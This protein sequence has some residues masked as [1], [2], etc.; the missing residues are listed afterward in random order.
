[1]ILKSFFKIILSFSIFVS[2]LT[3]A[4]IQE[5]TFSISGNNGETGTGSFTWDDATVPNGSTLA[6]FDYPS[7]LLSV[8]ITIS[9]GNIVGGSTSFSRADCSE[10]VLQNTPNFAQDINFW[11][12][13]GS[14][15][16][17]GVEVYTNDLNTG[18]NGAVSTLTFSPGSTRAYATAVPTMS[19]YGLALTVL[20]LFIS[21]IWRLRRPV[22]RA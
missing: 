3:M 1:M 21:A 7:A 20:A 16:L 8:S 9:G 4:A 22:S 6:D 19:A 12:D 17:E 2:S 15:T 5:H 10:A 18:G 14:N 11:C 13:N